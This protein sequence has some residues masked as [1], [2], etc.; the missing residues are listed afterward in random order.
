MTAGRSRSLGQDITRSN[1]RRIA[2]AGIARTFQHVKL[3]SSMSLIDNVLLGA[4]LRTR[5][6]FLGGA[7]RLD[8][9]EE[10]ACAFRSFAAARSASGLGANPYD[11]A[12]NLPLGRQRILEVARALA[13]D[14]ALIILDEPAAGLSRPDKQALGELLRALRA[15]RRHRPPG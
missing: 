13:A 15:G 5:A 1:Q 12:G 2:K 3:R 11:L 6:G 14:P 4:Y 7:L 9:A 10:G 8:R